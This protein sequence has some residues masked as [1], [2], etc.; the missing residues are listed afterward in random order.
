MKEFYF[1]LITGSEKPPWI[2]TRYRSPR[3]LSKGL[4]NP[5]LFAT[6][7]AAVNLLSK[8]IGWLSWSQIKKILEITR[9]QFRADVERRFVDDLILYLDYKIREGRQVTNER[10]QLSLW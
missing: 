2:L 6:S 7:E 4:G 8:G 10:K 5:R 3:N 9:G 1:I